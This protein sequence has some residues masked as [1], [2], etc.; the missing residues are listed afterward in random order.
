MLNSAS[1]ARYPE[2]HNYLA[3]TFWTPLD[4]QGAMST[5]S[6]LIGEAPSGKSF[7]IAVMPGHGAAGQ[8]LP[9]KEAAYSMDERTLILTYAIWKEAA[10]DQSN[11]RW[12]KDVVAKLEP[13]SKG[14][15]LSEADLHVSPQRASRCFSQANWQRL[16]DLR[17]VFDPHGTFHG[18]PGAGLDKTPSS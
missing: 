17:R 1:D 15:F 6:E 11:R 10:D 14:H 16:I 5:I 8:G 9:D 3:D 18:F 12:M 7:V 4:V 13:I 2:N